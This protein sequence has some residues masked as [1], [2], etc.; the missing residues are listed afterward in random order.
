MALG[1]LTSEGI[2]TRAVSI[3]RLAGGISGVFGKE[4]SYTM[5]GRGNQVGARVQ[6]CTK[7]GVDFGVGAGYIAWA[8]RPRL[9][10]RGA[11]SG[12]SLFL[13][14]GEWNGSSVYLSYGR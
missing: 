9:L 11:S 14:Q 6:G 7:R 3:F 10:A 13:S 2:L 12:V 5:W 8:G 1:A 4:A